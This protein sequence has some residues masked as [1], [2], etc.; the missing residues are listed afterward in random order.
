MT[1]LSI[2]M[3]KLDGSF[4]G[5]NGDSSLS[6]LSHLIEQPREVECLLATPLSLSL[7]LV[8]FIM[9]DYVQFQ[10]QVTQQGTLA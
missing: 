10:E 4:V 1:L 5:V 7:V 6:L 8:D 3:T 2:L 9:S